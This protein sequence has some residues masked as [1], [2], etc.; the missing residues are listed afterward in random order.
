M[1]VREGF[2]PSVPFD[3]YGALAKRCF[4]PLSHL[5][6]SPSRTGTRADNMPRKRRLPMPQFRMT[7]VALR[8]VR[9]REG[10]HR[11]GSRDQ[12]I[13]V[14][15]PEVY[16]RFVVLRIFLLFPLNLRQA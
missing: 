15:I 9:D 3:R 1:A 5:T 7:G 14:R 2:E 12:Q 4:R 8:S 10:N 13:L 16:V 6:K 11:I